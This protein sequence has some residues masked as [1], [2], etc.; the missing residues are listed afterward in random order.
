MA[1]SAGTSIRGTSA[2]AGKSCPQISPHRKSKNSQR[3]KTMKNKTW[4]KALFAGLA[5][6]SLSMSGSY[7]KAV[8]NTKAY[9]NID[10]AI[11]ANLSVSVSTNGV[12]AGDA[13]ST[14]T[15]TWNGS[16]GAN[17]KFV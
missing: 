13:S 15:V 9:L 7:A 8:A 14:Q 12:E 1:R 11:T 2:P 5:T 16:D 6:L 17:K 4:T 10:V 3:R